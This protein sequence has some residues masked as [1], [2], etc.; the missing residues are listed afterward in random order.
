MRIFRS[1]MSNSDHLRRRKSLA[2]EKDAC[3]S[4]AIRHLAFLP[5]IKKLTLP[6]LI[7]VQNSDIF[8]VV[9][10]IIEATPPPIPPYSITTINTF[11]CVPSAPPTPRPVTASANIRSCIGNFGSP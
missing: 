7:Y 1:N 10:S 6:C 11:I 4:T 9:M 8:I 3:S 5:H 2:R